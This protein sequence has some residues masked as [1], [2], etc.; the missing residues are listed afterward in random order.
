LS[1]RERFFFTIWP[2]LTVFAD[3]RQPLGRFFIAFLFS[4]LGQDISGRVAEY[5]GVDSY[6]DQRVA[7]I[8]KRFSRSKVLFEKCVSWRPCFVNIIH[9]DMNMFVNPV[10]K[11]FQLAVSMKRMPPFTVKVGIRHGAND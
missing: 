8:Q 11:A 1:Y 5:H 7:P 6:R 4:Y 10:N 3:H 9:M 2:L